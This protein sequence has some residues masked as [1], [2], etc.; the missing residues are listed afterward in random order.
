M[1][2]NDKDFFFKIWQ[3][4]SRKTAFIILDDRVF[5]DRMMEV[6]NVEFL[7]YK[8]L[9]AFVEKIFHTKPSMDRNLLMIL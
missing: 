5:A 9:Q 4:I 8:Y 6:L 2:D 1:S 3:N 7:E